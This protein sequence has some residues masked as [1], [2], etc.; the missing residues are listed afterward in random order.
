MLHNFV[1]ITVLHTINR[2]RDIIN[3]VFHL[4]ILKTLEVKGVSRANKTP[5]TI[6]PDYCRF[7]TVV[8]F[9]KTVAVLD[10]MRNITNP[11]SK[12]R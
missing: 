10:K 12:E 2:S 5:C 3:L 6:T 7:S 4:E 8:G 9:V 1:P 11:L